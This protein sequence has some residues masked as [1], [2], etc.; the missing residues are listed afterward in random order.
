MT[1]ATPA[2]GP[3]E[4]GE[5]G[6]NRGAPL[7]RADVQG[8]TEPYSHGPCLPARTWHPHFSVPLADQG[9]AST[10]RGFGKAWNTF[11]QIHEREKTHEGAE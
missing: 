9:M 10:G 6:P 7:T 1:S 5:G 2:L 8:A 4:M 11:G 3:F